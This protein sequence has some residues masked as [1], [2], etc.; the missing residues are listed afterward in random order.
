[1]TN[2]LPEEAVSAAFDWLRE[3]SDVVAA[4]KINMLR[5]EFMAKKI[6]AKLFRAAEGSIDARKAWATDH[7]D[8]ARAM[9]EYFQAAELWE[10]LMDRRN[11]CEAC[12]EAWR[13]QEASQRGVVRASR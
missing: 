10:Q 1:M 6:H 7:D 4:A 8:Y 2:W 13:T 12:L 5:K 11:K 3:A 9:E